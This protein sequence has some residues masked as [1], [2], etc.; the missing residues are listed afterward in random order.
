MNRTYLANEQN[1]SMGLKVWKDFWEEETTSPMERTTALLMQIL[2]DNKDTEYGRRYGFAEIRSVEDY[3][4]RVP[5]VV[6]DDIAPEIERMAKGEK[7]ILTAYPFSHFNETSG[8][9]GIPKLIPMSDRQAEV[10][11]QYNNLLMYGVMRDKLNP[12]WMNGRAFCTSSG[13]FRTLESGLTVGCASSK[14]AEH[15]QGGKDAL[16]SILRTMYTSP[17]EAMVS[18]PGTDA[19]YIHARFALMDREVRGMITGFY[20]VLVLFLR[21]IADN[22][23]LLINDIEKGTISPEIEM[24]DSVRESLLKK[25][26]PMPERAAEL[27]EIFKN[28][29]DFPF[30]RKIWP[31]FRYFTGAGGDGFEIYDKMLKEHFT[32]GGVANVYSGVTASEGLW[33]VPSGVDS[34][35]SILAPSAAFVEFL[36]VEAGNDFSQCVT[37]DK[38]EVGKIYELIITNLSGFYR[39]RMSDAVQVTGY[40][41]KTPTVQFM[42]RVN[43]TINLA[44]EKT[45]EKALQIAMEATA[46]E[47]GYTLADFSVYP[48]ADASPNRYVFLIEPMKEITEFDMKAL[49]ECVFKN[50]CRANPVYLEC[51]EE[52]ELGKPEAYFLQPETSLLYRDMMVYR[53]ASRDQLKPV[54]VIVNE[55]QRRFFFALKQELAD[56]SAGPAND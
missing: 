1:A 41:N 20:S 18:E 34:F 10:F 52:G 30:V 31:N 21:Y 36:P 22:R 54:R 39:Y 35:D 2:E 28:G 11:A 25:L 37:M 16:D 51:V 49:S 12:D 4:K 47:M 38:L 23:E 5:V 7:N 14:M 56:L 3:R 43:R 15:I 13:T 27:R 29:S 48:D 40:V 33:S 42:Y 32:G 8:T 19:K 46:E 45:T 55:R 6:Y 9:V 44:A 50:L 26:E 17:L 53:G 24:P